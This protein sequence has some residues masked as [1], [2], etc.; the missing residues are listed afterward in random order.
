[1]EKGKERASEADEHSAEK[2]SSDMA[3][4]DKPSRQTDVRY[5]R[6]KLFDKVM[7]TSLNKYIEHAR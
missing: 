2:P 7:Q 3:A 1:M 6:L 5:N 4:V